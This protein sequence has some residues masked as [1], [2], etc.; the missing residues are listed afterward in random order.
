MY[1]TKYHPCLYTPQPQPQHTYS[2][3]VVTI[4]APSHLLRARFTP[5]TVCLPSNAGKARTRLLKRPDLWQHILNIAT[6]VFPIVTHS[7]LSLIVPRYLEANECDSVLPRF[8]PRAQSALRWRRQLLV[9][10]LAIAFVSVVILL[11]IFPSFRYFLLPSIGLSSLLR[12]NPDLPNIRQYDLANFQGTAK[13]WER[14]E[15][16]LLCAPLRDAEVNLPLFFGHLRNFTYPH[17][18]IDMAFLVSDS[19]D[20]T[21]LSLVEGLEKLQADPDPAMH[22]G[23]ISVFEK[24][25]G[26]KVQQDFTNRH[27]FAA[28]APRRKLMAQ[29]RN[30]LLTAAL[31]PYH[32]WVYWR[33]VDVETAPATI[34]EDLMRHN[35][36]VIVPSRF[37]I[38]MLK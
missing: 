29:A 23:E 25:F 21:L 17:H 16:I 11:V 18:L 31:Q 13:G 6:S 9:K 26:Q 34:L 36:D 37:L 5:R 27:G 20:R 12:N 33:D 1:L 10:I 7:Q 14:G 15:R 38:P 22:Y 19:K 4:A 32:T 8:Q 3:T 2:Q 30:W 24:D 28:Q 35:K